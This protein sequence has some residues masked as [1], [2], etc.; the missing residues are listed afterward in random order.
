[1]GIGDHTT[2]P[3]SGLLSISRVWTYLAALDLFEVVP[4]IDDFPAALPTFFH[5]ME[6]WLAWVELA[7]NSAILRISI[8]LIAPASL[9][10]L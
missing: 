2:F 10:F 1:L 9:A 8:L 3:E 6:D 4:I 5:V 7:G